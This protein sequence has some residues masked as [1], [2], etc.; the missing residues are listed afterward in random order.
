[1]SA[2]TTRTPA[3]ATQRPAPTKT[4]PRRLRAW[5]I[6]A[7]AVA[8]ALGI[9]VWMLEN[10]PTDQI[11]VDRPAAADLRQ[12][13]QERVYF[14]HQSVGWNI[15]GGLEELYAGGDAAPL[16][17]ETTE[18]IDAAAFLAHSGVGVNGDPLSKLDE[19]T[20]VIDGPLGD[21]LDVAVLKFCY[22]DVTAATDAQALFDAYSARIAELEA[23]H[24]DIAF[25]YTTVP[26]T[27]D[28]SW[29]ANIKAF[30]GRDDQAGPADNVVRQ[31]YNT[32]V[33]ER[34]AG[35]GRLF[36]IAAVQA[37]MTE[38]PTLR[39]ADGAEYYVLNRALASDNGHLNTTGSLAAA[40]EFV[41]VIA[42]AT[43]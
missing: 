42:G 26:L 36:D 24:P 31:Q 40:S 21:R 35:T 9:G 12:F 20:A 3:Q 29:K 18:P 16:V 27:T 7:G 37:T 22:I 28:R 41:R 25:V 2:T 32:L 14:G 8:A 17:R 43:R 34:Y 4:R 6:A 30:L 33:R 19:F 15:V 23:R 1:M 38:R 11:T 5:L 10:P 39:G 13:A